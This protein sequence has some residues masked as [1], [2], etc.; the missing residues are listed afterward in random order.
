MVVIGIDPGTAATGYGVVARRGGRLV[1]LD[2]GVIATAAGL[3]L[4]RRLASIHARVAEL[5]EQHGP[6]AMAIEE[7]YFGANVRTAFAVGQARGVVLLAAG[8][9]GVPCRGYTPQQVKGAVC[10]SGRAEKG[11]VQRMVQ[12]LLSL[13]EL[14]RPDHAADALAVA[15]C[16]AHRAPLSDALATIGVR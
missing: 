13:P 11:Q 1:A 4:E 6:D 2:G 10:G 16:H 3:P 8:E 9:R 14:P 15:I 12:S 7:L 5:L